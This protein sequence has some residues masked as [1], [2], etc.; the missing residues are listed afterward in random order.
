MEVDKHKS[1][2]ME[3]DSPLVETKV[4][5]SLTFGATFEKEG[6]EAETQ[7]P[8]GGIMSKLGGQNPHRLHGK[9]G[10]I[11]DLRKFGSLKVFGSTAEADE[12]AY[13]ESV[14]HKKACLG[15]LHPDTGASGS[16]D[17]LQC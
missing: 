13:L 5:E 10:D 9:L 3:V 11:K 15:F 2:F 8:K 6:Y 16:Y 14:A 17:F 1:A 7:K 4:V 12:S